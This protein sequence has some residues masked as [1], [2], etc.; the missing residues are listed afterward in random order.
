MK[1]YAYKLFP[2]DDGTNLLYV[3]VHPFTIPVDVK[4]QIEIPIQI[5]SGW[6]IKSIWLPARP[7]SLLSFR[8]RLVHAWLVFT[9]KADILV[10]PHQDN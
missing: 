4:K 1:Y 8:Q 3:N 10:W 6:I 5:R 7:K 2:K 9:G